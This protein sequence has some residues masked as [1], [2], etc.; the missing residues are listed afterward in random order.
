MPSAFLA[1]VYRA[2]QVWLL[3]GR[4]RGSSVRSSGLA[5]IS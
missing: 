4:M 5:S 3:Y 1:S 2:L